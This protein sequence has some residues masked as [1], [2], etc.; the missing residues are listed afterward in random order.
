MA[1]IDLL[2]KTLNSF[3]VPAMDSSE[4]SM[5]NATMNL[6]LHFYV[7]LIVKKL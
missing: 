2:K 1:S 7:L 3:L 6:N 4:V 5:Y